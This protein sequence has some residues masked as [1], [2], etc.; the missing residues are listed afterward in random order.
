MGTL[1]N[2]LVCIAIAVITA[3]FAFWKYNEDFEDTVVK[4]I[5]N[6]CKPIKK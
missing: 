4:F 3:P 5:C 6:I 1:L 2:I